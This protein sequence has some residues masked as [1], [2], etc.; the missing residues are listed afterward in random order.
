MDASVMIFD[1]W[2]QA[3]KARVPRVRYQAYREAIVKFD[4]DFRKPDQVPVMEN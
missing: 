2:E 1:D 4:A 3:L